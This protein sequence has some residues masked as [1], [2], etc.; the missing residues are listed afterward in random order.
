MRGD[1]QY[2]RLKHKVSGK[3]IVVDTKMGNYDRL[4]KGFLN[5]IK[6][7]PYFVKHLVLTQAVESYKPRILNKFIFYLNRYYGKVVHI[8]SVEIQEERFEKTGCAVLHWHLVVGFPYEVGKSFGREDIIRIQKYWKYGHVE[9]VP[10]FKA[11]LSYLMK[12][13]TKDLYSG[14][15]F[16]ELFPGVRRIGTSRISAWLKQGFQAVLACM[17]FFADVNQDPDSF[18][19]YRGNAFVYEDSKYKRGRLYVYRRKKEWEVVDWISSVEC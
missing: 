7:K 14:E 2:L 3:E 8:W 17:A 10:Y 15:L 5:T 19:W 18:Y 1:Y 6:L 13:L 16:K 12:Y 11:T 9:I 4:A